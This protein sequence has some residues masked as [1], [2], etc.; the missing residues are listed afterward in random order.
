MKPKYNYI[1]RESLK[2]DKVLSDFIEEDLLPK[3]NVA[4]SLM[5]NPNKRGIEYLP[6]WWNFIMFFVKILPYKYAAKL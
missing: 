3:S 4:K 1:L 2:V 5:N 6:W